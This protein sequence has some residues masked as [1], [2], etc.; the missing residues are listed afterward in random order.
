MKKGPEAAFFII[1]IL[2]LLFLV[3]QKNRT[4]KEIFQDRN[5]LRTTHIIQR[6]HQDMEKAQEQRQEEKWE[7]FDED[8]DCEF[9]TGKY[10]RKKA[11][12]HEIGESGRPRW[13]EPFSKVD[14]FGK[15]TVFD[16]NFMREPK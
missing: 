9:G 3:A 15:S 13:M 11:Y 14:M 1:I 10:A 4:T 16:P 12:A 5:L 7:K 6:A 2:I 8:M